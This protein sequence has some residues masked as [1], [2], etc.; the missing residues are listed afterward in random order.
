MKRKIAVGILIVLIFAGL[1][2][3]IKGLQISTLIAASKAFVQ[4]PES[5]SSFVVRRETWPKT[6]TA[7]GSVVAVQGVDITTEVAGIITKIA[8]ESGARVRQGEVLIELDSSTEQ[9]QLR[10]M[11]AQADLARV[12]AERLRQLRADNTVSQAELDAAEASLKQLQASADAIRA[13][14]DKKIIR[15]PFAGI[16][17]IRQVNLGEYLDPGEPIVSLQSLAP[18]FVRFSLPQQELSRLRTGM[19]VLAWADAYPDKRFEGKLTAINP[20]LKASTRSVQIQATFENPDQE[21]RP[22]MFVRVE[23]V[24]ESADEVVVVPSTAVLGAPYGDS[25]YL[26]EPA[27]NNTGGLV[28][29]QQ[30]VRTGRARGDFVSIESGLQPGQT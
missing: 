16:L 28:V 1:L 29:R 17:G 10:A 25:V 14:I 4:P 12:N 19:I 5:V 11:E 7:I 21:L 22:G 3:G 20:D 2:G 27:T 9:A 23:V 13:A 6:L 30:F 15:A 18:V 26:I 8:F 24:L